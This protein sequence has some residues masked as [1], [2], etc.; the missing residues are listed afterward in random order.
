[1]TVTGLQKSM[2]FSETSRHSKVTQAVLQKQYQRDV[3]GDRKCGRDLPALKRSGQGRQN[4]TGVTER[5]SS[6]PLDKLQPSP[7][8]TALQTATPTLSSGCSHN[9][10]CQQRTTNNT[11]PQSLETDGCFIPL[12]TATNM[13]PY[14]YHLTTQKRCVT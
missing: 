3:P 5:H 4:R 14:Y 6:T 1:M 10:C 11:N 13:V 12:Q 2:F 8:H 7:V 9:R